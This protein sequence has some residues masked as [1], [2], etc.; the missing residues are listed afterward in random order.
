[1][2]RTQST[3]TRTLIR[4]T[5]EVFAALTERKGQLRELIQNSNRTWQAIASRDQ[6]FADTFTRVPDLPAREPRD[7]QRVTPFARVANPLV[8]QLRPAARQ[9]SPTLISLDQL[10]PD[11]RASSRTSARSCASR[12]RAAGHE[13]GAR[14]HAAAAAPAR[15]V[16]P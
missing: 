14:Q 8:T 5:G 10:A 6:Q 1:M 7:H 4:D 16:P 11:L 13:P 15:P 3:A 9:I 2:L 12:G